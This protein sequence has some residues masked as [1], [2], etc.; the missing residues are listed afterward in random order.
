MCLGGA[1]EK[2][3]LAAFSGD[4]TRALTSPRWP[5]EPALWD[6]RSGKLL[7]TLRGHRGIITCAS[8]NAAGDRVVTG[9]QD[10]TARVWDAASGEPLAV[11]Q[12]HESGIISAAFSPDGAR[13]LTTD[14]ALRYVFSPIGDGSMQSYGYLNQETTA[15]VWDARSGEGLFQLGGH[16]GKV[17]AALSADGKFILTASESGTGPRIWEASSGKLIARLEALWGTSSAAFSA[18]SKRLLIVSNRVRLPGKGETG[19]EGSAA[20]RDFV[21]IWEVGSWKER[22]RLLGHGNV[23]HRASF[24]PDGALVATASEDTVARVWDSG[25]GELLL[26]L[27]GHEGGVLTADFNPD[28]RRIFTTSSDGTARV[29]N[30]DPRTRFAIVPVEIDGSVRSALFSPDGSRLLTLSGE[31]GSIW[32]AESGKGCPLA[33][34]PRPQ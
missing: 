15:R 23:V 18:D 12:G 32:A 24:S 33:V 10:A 27:R 8:F 6:T 31:V 14:E 17:A 11:Y 19:G 3:S 9:S 34:L 2:V 26:E 7:G 30:A 21:S 5:P 16:G 25:T 1:A 20:P 4:G 28:G 22:T 13:V 29:W